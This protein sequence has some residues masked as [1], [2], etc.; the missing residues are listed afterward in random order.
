MGQITSLFARKVIGEVD[1]SADRDALLRSVGV[2]P[3]GRS[4][5]SQMVPD[6]STTLLREVRGG[7]LER[8]DPALAGRRRH[9]LRRV[10]RV[11][12]G[13]EVGDG[14]SGLL[15]ARGALCASADQRVDVR[16]GATDGG[17]VH[18]S[19][20]SGER[21]RGCACPTKP[22]SRASSP[23]AR[24][25]RRGVRTPRRVLQTS[26]ARP[27]AA[28]TKPTSAARSTSTSDRDALLVSDEALRT[29][30]KVGDASI[31]GSSTPIS[32]P[33]CRSSTTTARSSDGCRI[34]SPNP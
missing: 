34:A 22:R 28:A 33:T 26:G 3:D 19:P 14:S 5:P 18:A 15:R 10:R 25:P 23:S 2:D 20:P 12:P 1:E 6:T 27:P 16:G 30:N 7:R 24:R 17:C 31:V 32:K 29:P 11:R 4:I 9:A 8:L 21:H 13:L